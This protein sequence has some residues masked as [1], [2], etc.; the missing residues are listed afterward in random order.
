M[1]AGLTRLLEDAKKE[2]SIPLRLV[3]A[4]RLM[5]LVKARRGATEEAIADLT[6]SL[7][8]SQSALTEDE[9]LAAEVARA[10]MLLGD[11]HARRD[12]ST[13]AGEAWQKAKTILIS[14]APRSNS[15][16]ILDPWARLLERFAE[17]EAAREWPR[18]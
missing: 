9:N 2:P 3:R 8:E 4:H 12:R 17:V 16:N 14:V 11:L 7:R 15:P 1:I 6:H 5:S 18:I 10:W 13:A